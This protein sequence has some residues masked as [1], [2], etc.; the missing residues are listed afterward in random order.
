MPE[1]RRPEIVNAFAHE[2]LIYDEL[3]ISFRLSAS[4]LLRT[5][6]NA[7]ASR[8]IT[9]R[10]MRR[11]HAQRAWGWW[12]RS[13]I[14]EELVAVGEPSLALRI[15]REGGHRRPR[16]WNDDERRIAASAYE[17]LRRPAQAKKM[18]ANPKLP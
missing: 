5:H 2:I 18:L 8:R 10:L 15:L 3:D 6:G 17:A 13:M 4:K 16:D 11:R 14:A 1:D 9:Y 7:E 12:C